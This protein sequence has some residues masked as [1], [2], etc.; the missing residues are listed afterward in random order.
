MIHPLSPPPPPPKK[1]K[2]EKNTEPPWAKGK[3]SIKF[4][5]PR[6]NCFG[7]RAQK[8]NDLDRWTD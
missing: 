5:V 2:K 3:T 4:P 1:K 6:S 8:Q 7:A